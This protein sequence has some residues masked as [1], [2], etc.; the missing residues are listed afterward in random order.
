MSNTLIESSI[1]FSLK[2]SKLINKE[3]RQIRTCGG[4]F[5]G[6]N[7]SPLITKIEKR[8]SSLMH[9]SMGHAVGL[10]VSHYEPEQEI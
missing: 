3:I 4:L 9:L 7:K 6:E 2:R 1:L 8:I 5:F 10:Q